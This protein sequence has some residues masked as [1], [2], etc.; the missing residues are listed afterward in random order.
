MKRASKILFLIL[1]VSQTVSAQYLHQQGKYI[2]DGNGEEFLIRSMGLGGW[3][4][5]EGYMLE[6]GSF[7]GTQHEIRALIE[8]SMGK[9]RTDDFYEAWLANHC[10]KTDIEP[11]ESCQK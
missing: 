10:T 6:T 8:N 5:Q 3:M 11:A 7:A 9:A 1:L 2:V 4:L